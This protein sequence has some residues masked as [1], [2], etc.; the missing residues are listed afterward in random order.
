MLDTFTLMQ[1]YPKNQ[2]WIFLPH[3]VYIFNG[4]G[5]PPVADC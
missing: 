5:D 4:I 2:D 3:P 1:K